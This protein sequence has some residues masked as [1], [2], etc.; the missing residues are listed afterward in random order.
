MLTLIGV[1]VGT[2]AACGADV[3]VGAGGE[4]TFVTA[5]AGSLTA[6]LKGR[7]LLLPLPIFTGPRRTARFFRSRYTAE[8]A[9]PFLIEP[10]DSL[11]PD[12][13]LL[14]AGQRLERGKHLVLYLFV[15]PVL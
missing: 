3:I 9:E 7:S 2:S 5:Q 6:Y 13:H 4:K 10:S 8:R 12:R 14:R 11:T 1:V 15:R